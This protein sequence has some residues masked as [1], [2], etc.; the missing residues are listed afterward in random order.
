V[1]EYRRQIEEEGP[2]VL[3]VR[4]G[5]ADCKEALREWID[6]LGSIAAVKATAQASANLDR[7]LVTNQ[8]T[9]WLS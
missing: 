4:L 7:A 9:D 1:K 6:A 3:G 2:K 5:E 8:E